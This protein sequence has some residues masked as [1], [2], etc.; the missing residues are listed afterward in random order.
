MAAIADDLA[1]AVVIRRQTAHWKILVLEDALQPRTF[2]PFSGIRTVAAIAVVVINLAS[3]GLL[4]IETEFGVGLAAFD[5]ATR[6]CRERKACSQS[7]ADPRPMARGALLLMPRI[8]ELRDS[9]VTRNYSVVHICAQFPTAAA[10]PL[11][12]Q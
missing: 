12:L 10:I 7:R 9:P 2:S 4:R 1:D 6:E 3:G 5:I 11:D 8:D